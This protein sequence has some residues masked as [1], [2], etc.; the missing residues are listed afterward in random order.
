MCVEVSG[1]ERARRRAPT[2]Q[3]QSVSGL[4]KGNSVGGGIRGIDK[5]FSSS[6]SADAV[7]IFLCGFFFLPFKRI[8]S[9]RRGRYRKGRRLSRANGLRGDDGRRRRQMHGNRTRFLFINTGRVFPTDG[10]HF[11][12]IA[13]SGVRRGGLLHGKLVR[14]RRRV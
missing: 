1:G 3:G 13:V 2:C 4:G 9:G 10:F 11:I 14:N 8:S 5:K 6:Q 7:D 12:S